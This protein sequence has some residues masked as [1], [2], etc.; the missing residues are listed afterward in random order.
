M[1]ENLNYDYKIDGVSH[2]NWC[3]NNEP[4]SCAKY[5]RLYTWA[6]AMDSAN[7]RCGY[8]YYTACTA[9]SGKVRGICPTGWHLPC[10]AEWDTLFAAVGGVDSAGTKLKST[11]GWY[12]NDN[13][14]DAYGF[15]ALPSGG[16]DG[17]IFG[18]AGFDANFWSSSEV[19][20]DYAYYYAYYVY[21]YYYY[22]DAKQDSS[23][24]YSGFAVRCVKD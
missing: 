10:V 24:K 20:Q 8:G 18:S 13:G 4:D 19:D 11:S 21:L 3:Y 23:Y 6:A 1:A 17:R 16:G 7:T 2:G 12:N 9:S 15:S 5:G 22:A 14:T